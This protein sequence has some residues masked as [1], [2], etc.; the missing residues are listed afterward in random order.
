MGRTITDENGGGSGDFAPTAMLKEKGAMLKGV[1]IGKRDVK[2][3]YGPKP[4]YSF[5]VL[6]ASCKFTT[7]KERT[8]VQPNEGD[9]VDAF[10]PTR[11]ARQLAQVQTGET[12]TITYQGTKKAGKGMPAHFY[13][14]EVA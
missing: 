5:Q 1:L 9:T 7:G 4:V 14:V 3:Q 13:S 11:L 10:A 2:T 12:V 6:D 8:E